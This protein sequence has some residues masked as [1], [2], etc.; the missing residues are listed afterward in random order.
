MEDGIIAIDQLYLLRNNTFLKQEANLTNTEYKILSLAMAKMQKKL[1]KDYKTWN[2]DTIKAMSPAME[3]YL[4]LDELKQLDIRENDLVGKNLSKTLNKLKETDVNFVSYITGGYVFSHL[5]SEFEIKK[6]GYIRTMMSKQVFM[7]L[8]DYNATF[9]FRH[10]FPDYEEVKESDPPKEKLITKGYTKMNIGTID[11]FKSYYTQVM[12]AHFKSKLEKEINNNKDVKGFDITYTVDWMRGA[13]GTIS[14]D[15]DGEEKMKHKNYA[16]FRKYV[17]NKAVKELEGFKYFK[18]KY[19]EHCK[20]KRVDSVTFHVE[21]GEELEYTNIHKFKEEI[22]KGTEKSE[23]N[24]KDVEYTDVK[25][26]NISP[27]SISLTMYEKAGIKIAT[28]TI[29]GFIRD[30]GLAYT[31]A[32]V[33][34]TI[35][36]AKD[37]TKPKLTAPVRYMQKVLNNLVVEERIKEKENESTVIEQ[38]QRNYTSN[39][40]KRLKQLKAEGKDVMGFNNVEPREYDYKK[41]ESELTNWYQSDE[42]DIQEMDIEKDYNEILRDIKSREEKDC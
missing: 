26:E 5:I 10:N 11:K 34:T 18:I 15:A 32:T 13:F 25:S 21:A 30:F 24:I 2:K 12:Y 36:R 3:C 42:D 1:L 40:S 17:I 14:V 31:K 27:A 38:G 6:N 8:L 37:K 33:N 4:H 23:S 41:L 20:G 16:D 9:D 29:E 39:N 28:S 22:S 35:N 7:F 19:T